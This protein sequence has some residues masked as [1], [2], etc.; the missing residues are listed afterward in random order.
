MKIRIV[1]TEIEEAIR[2]HIENMIA[3]K[4]G[5]VI[6]MD[7][8]AT[9]SADGLI[10]DIDISPAGTTTQAAPAAEAPA[11]APAPAEQ[12]SVQAGPSNPPPSATVQTLSARRQPA[13]SSPAP[14]PVAQPEPEP[15]VEVQVES[16]PAQVAE[17]P[18]AEDDE[19][20]PGSAPLKPSIFSNLRR[21]SNQ[22]AEAEA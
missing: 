15:E 16:A 5:M 1:Q 6:T 14:A 21:P 11:A 7:F 22:A 4:P 3:L 9:R 20:V 10:A 13:V 12:V 2:N 17:A 18:E 19:A 8:S